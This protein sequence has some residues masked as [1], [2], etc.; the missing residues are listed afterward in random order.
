MAHWNPIEKLLGDAYP[1]ARHI[2]QMTFLFTIILGCIWIARSLVPLLFPPG[3][4]LND[5]LHLVDSFASILGIVGYVVWL[6]LD[7]FFLLKE[8][9]TDFLRKDSKE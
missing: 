8:R 3:Q 2:F 6:G 1:F 5:F 7:L 4:F 9:F